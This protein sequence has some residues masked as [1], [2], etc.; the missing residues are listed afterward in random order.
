MFVLHTTF[1]VACSES[2]CLYLRHERCTHSPMT[3]C[4]VAAGDVQ[5]PSE[6]YNELDL[7]VRNRLWWRA[8]KA[9][10]VAF[11]HSALAVRDTFIQ[12]CLMARCTDCQAGSPNVHQ[13]AQ[14][15]SLCHTN[16]NQPGPISL[17]W[18]TTPDHPQPA[19]SCSVTER[20]I[21]QILRTI[22]LFAVN[23]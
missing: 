16:A 8:F 21:E 19:C 3:Q 13:S 4:C 15:R 6:K 5:T 22:H 7:L 10:G 23:A 9:K 18:V 11:A 1:A 12:T 2:V 14:V 20:P 17:C